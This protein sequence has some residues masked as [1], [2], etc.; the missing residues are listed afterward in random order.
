MVTKEDIISEVEK[1]PDDKV[2]E[3]YLLVKVFNAPVGDSNTASV[4]DSGADGE[5]AGLSLKG[6]AGA[7]GEDEPEYS[8]S[9]LREPNPDY[10]GR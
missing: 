6:L 3:L 4:N 9:L 1:T 5:W 10:E 8:L 7:Y 2:G